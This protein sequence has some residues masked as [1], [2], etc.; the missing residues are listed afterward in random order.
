MSLAS[1]TVESLDAIQQTILTLGDECQ[2]VASLAR[3][4]STEVNQTRARVMDFDAIGQIV[5]KNAREPPQSSS[6]LALVLDEL[7]NQFRLL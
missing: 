2:Q 1:E 7:V 5:V 4:S 6:E 3:T